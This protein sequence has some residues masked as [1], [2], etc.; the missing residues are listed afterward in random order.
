M[1]DDKG[2]RFFYGDEHGRVAVANIP[3]VCS[4]N[5]CTSLIAMALL[6]LIVVKG[7][8]QQEHIQDTGWCDI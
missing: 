6:S 3:R 5:V 1:W 2:F 7:T 8:R 4:D